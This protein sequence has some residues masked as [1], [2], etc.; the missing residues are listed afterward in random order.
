MSE[1]G[2]T[3][4]GFRKKSY[5]DILNS[6]KERAQTFFGDDVNL[7]S[8]SPLGLFIRLFAFSM[9]LIWSIAEKV[10]NAAYVNT[11]TGQSLDHVAK[12]LNIQRKGA[13]A[14]EGEITISGA[15]GT[16][17]PKGFTVETDF[18]SSIKFETKYSTVIESGGSVTTS[19]VAKEPGEVG[20]VQANTITVITN[21]ISGVEAVN[22]NAATDYGRDRENDH[23]LRTRYFAQLGQNSSD[24]IQAVTSAISDI[25]EVR[26]VKVFEN[27]TMEENSLGV[28][29]KS[30][31]A[32]VL[33]GSQED[34]AQAI[35]TA[36]AGGIQAY[37]D[38]YVEV[39]DDADNIHQ[40]GFSRPVS[41]DTY[42]TIDLQTNDDYPVEGDDL[43]KESIADYIE[44][45]IIDDNIVHSKIINVIHNSVSGIEDFELYI[46]TSENP[47]TKDNIPISGLEVA[48]T[49]ESK[50]VINH[51]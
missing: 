49:D 44:G 16:E 18:D 21:P 41:V 42:Y 22:N 15:P 45:L 39:L 6:L 27:D 20:N 8:A 9:S 50:V 5:E 2:V 47:T 32:V 11:A 48:T 37:G 38:V 1:Y 14:S 34:I 17:I 13:R 28:P 43:I 36:K 29:A 51:V 35:F 4:Q 3:E 24:V 7:S 25:N 10:Y 30:V 19:I 46:G 26:Q 23:E 40:I 33:G 12:N 31:F